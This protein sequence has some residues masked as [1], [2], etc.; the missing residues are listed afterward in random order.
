MVSSFA[1]AQTTLVLLY[2]ALF[3]CAAPRS[4]IAARQAQ[5]GHGTL[6]APSSGLTIAEGSDFPFTF[7]DVNWCEDGYSPISVW[8]TDYA[9]A[10]SN[11]NSTGQFPEGQ[12]T[13]YFG[14]YLIPNFG[15]PPLEGNNPP[16]STLTLPELESLAKGDKVYLSVVET[17]TNCPPGTNIPP[18]YELTNVS[19]TIG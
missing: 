4:D 6:A 10:A 1:W 3:A 11:L 19:I 9:P 17:G 5:S 15:L 12:Y 2:G 13:Y 14:E 18:Q 7:H 8:L 16:P